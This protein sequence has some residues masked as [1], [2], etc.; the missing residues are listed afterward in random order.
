VLRDGTDRAKSLSD[1]DVTAARTV[2]KIGAG[3]LDLALAT[4]VADRVTHGARTV[5]LVDAAYMGTRRAAVPAVAA[6][7]FVAGRA[8]KDEPAAARSLLYTDAQPAR[9]VE[10]LVRAL[11]RRDLTVRA[12]VTDTYDSRSA[13]AA[14]F[15][16]GWDVVSPDQRQWLP[17][18]REAASTLPADLTLRHW[19]T[20]LTNLAELLHDQQHGGRADDPRT[21][22]LLQEGLEA[23]HALAHPGHKSKEELALPYL[24][25]TISSGLETE[26]RA[27]LYAA[28]G[29][30]GAALD[31]LGADRDAFAA[32]PELALDIGGDAA[33]GRDGTVRDTT[34]ARR[35]V[36]LVSD[37]QRERGGPR[38]LPVPE[39]G[40]ARRFAAEVAK[41]DIGDRGVQPWASVRPALPGKGTSLA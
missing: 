30:P 37:L 13:P 31:E 1:D 12:L 39:L 9:S 36:D 8:T 32:R 4:A 15:G 29:R 28:A 26:G 24:T 41:R 5:D 21:R 7:A 19:T 27:E 6:A 33:V 16:A 22:R 14:P 11:D 34:I 40:T 10:A 20:F 2:Q 23:L 17:L 18:T 25:P 38:R 3:D 35:A